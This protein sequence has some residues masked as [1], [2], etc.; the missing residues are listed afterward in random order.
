MLYLRV[1]SQEIVTVIPHSVRLLTWGPQAHT[2]S[3]VCWKHVC[4]H[5]LF[6]VAIRKKDPLVL[7]IEGARRQALPRAGSQSGRKD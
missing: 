3:S 7:Q 4:V 2:V 6:P 5:G 1:S